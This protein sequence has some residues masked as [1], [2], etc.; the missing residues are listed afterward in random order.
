LTSNLVDPLTTSAGDFA[1]QVLALKLNV[2][3]NDAGVL[4]GT[5]MPVHFGDLYI[6]H[7]GNPGLDDQ[8]VRAILGVANSWVGHV[9]QSGYSTT[10]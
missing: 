10:L 9:F 2:D 7:T 6:V 5:S 4:G 8:T 3:L 1:G